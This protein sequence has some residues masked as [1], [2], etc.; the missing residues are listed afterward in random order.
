MRKLCEGG[1]VLPLAVKRVQFEHT[2]TKTHANVHTHARVHA[3]TH[4]YTHTQTH[5]HT[6]CNVNS[7][8]LLHL[9]LPR[10]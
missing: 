6:H 9:V 3:R 4:A 7:E 8:K 1:K 5:I 10:L 2:H